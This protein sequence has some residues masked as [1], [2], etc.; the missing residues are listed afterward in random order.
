MD[1]GLRTVLLLGG[2][3]FVV[4]FAAMTLTVALTDGVTILVVTS[5]V[6][7]GMLGAAL[8]GALRDPPD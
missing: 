2:L 3:L 5:V 6:I 7:V 4:L 1:P 8:I